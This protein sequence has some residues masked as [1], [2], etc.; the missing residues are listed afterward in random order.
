MGVMILDFHNKIGKQIG[1]LYFYPTR[2]IVTEQPLFPTF[3]RSLDIR[4][5]LFIPTVE[6]A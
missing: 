2:R 6:S 3:G 1:K 4:L 5:V